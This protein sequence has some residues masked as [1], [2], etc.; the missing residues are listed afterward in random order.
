[1]CDIHEFVNDSADDS[2]DARL[3][4]EFGVIRCFEYDTGRLKCNWAGWVLVTGRRHADAVADYS[5]PDHT[6]VLLLPDV[7]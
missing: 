7:C 4:E 2:A 3:F 1:M 6:L 5:S